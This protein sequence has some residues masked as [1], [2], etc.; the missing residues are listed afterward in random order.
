MRIDKKREVITALLWSGSDENETVSDAGLE[1]G[2]A[3]MHAALAAHREVIWGVDPLGYEDAAT[4]AA[5][6]L[7]ETS[8]TLCCEWF[9]RSGR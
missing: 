4:E 3:T 5:Y 8:P 6:R 9:G 1:F 2:R 7:I